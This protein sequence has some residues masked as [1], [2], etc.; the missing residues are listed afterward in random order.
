MLKFDFFTIYN[1]YAIKLSKGVKIGWSVNIESRIS[2][3]KT[4]GEPVKL[5]KQIDVKNRKYEEDLKQI[6]KKLK[7]ILDTNGT[8]T[9]VYDL[10]EEQ[11]VEILEHIAKN[12][13]ITEED[14]VNILKSVESPQSFMNFT[15][16]ELC[17][18]INPNVPRFQR[19]ACIDHVV[20]IKKYIL[21]KNNTPCYYLSNIILCKTHQTYL[22]IDG[23]HRILAIQEIYKETPDHPVLQNMIQCV[24]FKNLTR[25]EQISLFISVNK[26]RQMPELYL[27]KNY[28]NNT[29]NSII[30]AFRTKYKSSIIEESKKKLNFRDTIVIDNALGPLLNN[31]VL[32]KLLCNN[33]IETSS[34][35]SIFQFMDNIN[36]KIRNS[37]CKLQTANFFK[38]RCTEL[39]NDETLEYLAGLNQKK[40]KYSS[41]NVDAAISKIRARSLKYAFVLGLVH[42]YDWEYLYNYE[43]PDYSDEAEIDSDSE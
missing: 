31:E 32:P 10:T 23:Q 1:M 36:E 25:E 29:R 28:F 38:I 13:Q 39:I 40:G 42:N 9:E 33:C 41:S 19:E 18:E 5:I 8:A 4:L 43:L 14:V 15:Y 16:L 35:T 24:I 7:K 34:A 6:M 37:I 17:K 26:S 21:E 22:I 11:A 27:D 12:K 3:Y 20:E 2:T 30:K